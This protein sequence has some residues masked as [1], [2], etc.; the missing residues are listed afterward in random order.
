MDEFDVLIVLGGPMN[1]Y[2]EDRYPYLIRL[3]DAIFKFVYENKPYLG[4][5][6]G[7]Q[8][9]AKALDAPVRK[10]RQREIGNFE[11]NLT[12]DVAFPVFQW[13]GDTFNI[14]K[15]AIKLAESKLCSNQAFRFKNSYGVQFHL[16]VTPKMLEEWIE[17]YRCELN[18]EGIDPSSILS[19]FVERVE[20]YKE[21]L[22]Q[23]LSNF[24]SI[25]VE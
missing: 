23:L 14:A 20:V 1:V 5:C 3:N 21:L 12:E 13:H 4:F 10:N 15:G 8:L 25:R 22:W 11:V 7:A 18:D 16:E 9:L 24:F 2:E 6:L 17:N 19:E